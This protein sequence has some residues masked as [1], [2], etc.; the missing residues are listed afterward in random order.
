MYL[1]RYEEGVMSLGDFVVIWPEDVNAREVVWKSGAHTVTWRYAPDPLVGRM[2][3]ILKMIAEG[4]EVSDLGLEIKKINPKAEE[5]ITPSRASASAKPL[6]AGMHFRDLQPG[7]PAMTQSPL[8]LPSQVGNHA[9]R[10]P[11]MSS[12]TAYATPV[13]EPPQEFFMG[14]GSEG[15]MSND[16]RTAS[17]R[18]PT[19]SVRD[20]NEIA[21]PLVKD[22]ESIS[23]HLQQIQSLGLSLGILY[24]EGT[25]IRVLPA[26]RLAFLLK[27]QQSFSELSN[28]A[29]C[30]RNNGAVFDYEFEPVKQ[31]LLRTFATKQMMKTAIASRLATLKC[32]SLTM[33][34]DFLSKASRIIAIHM[35]V[36]PD[37]SS[38]YRDLIR[39]IVAK[40]PP[41]ISSRI[42]RKLMSTRED[43]DWER[44]PFDEASRSQW[45]FG[46]VRRFTV[47]EL[48][49]EECEV[50]LLT[51]QTAGS[52][53]A[54]MVQQSP[55]QP[56][57]NDRIV[58][59][60]R[61]KNCYF[62][63]VIRGT[64]IKDLE[65]ELRKC[66]LSYKTQLSNKGRVPY[67]LVGSNEAP[68][69]IEGKLEGLPG[70]FKFGPAGRTSTPKN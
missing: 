2:A 21:I 43:D 6:E 55:V 61:Y 48:V 37:D 53:M 33:V 58:F 12:G 32:P 63:S 52:D 51:S 46:N 67:L 13:S 8:R 34:E 56:Q 70:V 39:K 25:R 5:A 16:S 10:Q 40:L 60:N 23:I 30:I 57:N 15:V 65:D 26:L 7:S 69:V 54:R 49:R 19:L 44:I 20:V 45:T 38:E 1:L 50:A 24:E 11:R 68:A 35:S 31:L 9:T 59:M 27:V 66:G 22:V 17:R 42:I 47:A 62:V 41:Q 4:H 3:E 64:N 18:L 29:D 28:V 14:A 36:Y